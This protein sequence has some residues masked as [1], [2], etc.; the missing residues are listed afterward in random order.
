MGTGRNR[1]SAGSCAEEVSKRGQVTLEAQQGQVAK[2]RSQWGQVGIGARRVRARKKGAGRLS[3]KGMPKRGQVT[4]E[5][6]QGQ[7]QRGEAN[8]DRSE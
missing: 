5:A 3:S 7:V 4:L 6:Q 1:C 8:G 2:R